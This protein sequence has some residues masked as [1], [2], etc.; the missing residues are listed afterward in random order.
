MS[1]APT[2][3]FLSGTARS[4]CTG[5]PQI[6]K[7]HSKPAKKYL[8]TIAGEYEAMFT[9][10]PPKTVTVVWHDSE[11]TRMLG[12]GAGSEESQLNRR[13]TSEASEEG[14]GKNLG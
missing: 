14:Y 2:R 11:K 4:D 12:F 6:L 10:G 5:L 3:H 9:D 13:K 8:D 7:D 1:P